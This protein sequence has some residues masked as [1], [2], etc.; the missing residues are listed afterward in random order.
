MIRNL[1]VAAIRLLALFFAVSALP[2]L[3]QG[4]TQYFLNQS[5]EF[6]LLL[7]I[8]PATSV[9]QIML[10]S[11][12]WAFS[13][14]IAKRI[15]QDAQNKDTVIIDAQDI[16]LIALCILGAI[17]II[18]SAPQIINI[19]LHLAH[20]AAANIDNPNPIRSRAY[21]SPS[22]VEA[23]IQ[24]FIGFFLLF[25]GFRL[26]SVLRKFQTLRTAG[27]DKAEPISASKTSERS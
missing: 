10:A 8:R 20:H 17:T 23:S 18:D 5:P 4:L 22:L 25:F 26:K 6:G 27:H 14:P 13:A 1:C 12:I 15:S 9:F 11:L 2:P 21:F 19:V 7:I 3:L 16:V 24:T